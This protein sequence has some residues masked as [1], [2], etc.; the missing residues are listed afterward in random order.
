MHADFAA[1]S[2]TVDPAEVAK[3]ER[4]AAEWWDPDGKFRPLHRLNPVRLA[5]IRD[6][7]AAHFGRDAAAARPF[8][9]LRVLDIGC[10]GGLLSEP[11]ARLGAD[12]VGA[13]PALETIAVARTHAEQ[14]GLA[15]DYRAESAEALLAAGERFDVVLAMEVV[16][17]VADMRAFLGACAGLL[18]PGGVVIV[19]TINRTLKA[20]ALAIVG[21]E[22]LLRWLP[23][24]THDYAKLV[25]PAELEGGLAA[26]GLLVIDRAGIVYDVL[27][28][29]W[30]RSADLDVN[31]MM[32]AERRPAE[33][34]A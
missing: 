2:A 30:V 33:P 32:V 1:P 4:L 24:G 19:A 29:R 28:D 31:Y 8:A 13:D 17:H 16:E 23:R 11:M 14:S 20:W 18:K 7:L 5:F 6:A 12:V 21:A 15:I 22:L 26:A 25:R 10:G 3:F 34:I 9:G 27:R